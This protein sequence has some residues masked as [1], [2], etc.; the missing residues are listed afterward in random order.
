[1]ATAQL[2]TNSTTNYIGSNPRLTMMGNIMGMEMSSMVSWPMNI[3]ITISSFK[4]LSYL[5]VAL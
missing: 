5:V 1:M 2:I 3:P 4:V